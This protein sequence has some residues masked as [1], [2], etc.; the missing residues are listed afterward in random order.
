MGLFGG[1]PKQLKNLDGQLTAA[2]LSFGMFSRLPRLRGLGLGDN[3]GKVKLI[4]GADRMKGL[5]LKTLVLVGLCTSGYWV[6]LA[7]MREMRRLF[8]PAVAASGQLL[9]WDDPDW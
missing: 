7:H 5:G 2:R 9:F 4:E 6:D 3:D 8:E 1:R